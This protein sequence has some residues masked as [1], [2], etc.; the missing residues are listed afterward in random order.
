MNKQV[1]A[2]N[3]NL[4]PER[5]DNFATRLAYYFEPVGIVGLN[6][7]QNTV[8]GLFQSDQLTAAQFGNT[9]P[10]FAQYTFLTTTPSENKVVIR[11]L[12]VEYSQSLSFLPGALKGLNA[13][14][15]YTRNYSSVITANMSPHGVN[16]GLS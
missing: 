8:K 2:P 5:S 9:D 16:A 1:S 4:K 12:E 7:F 11:G 3:P 10:D 6:L 13:R 15:S 14:L